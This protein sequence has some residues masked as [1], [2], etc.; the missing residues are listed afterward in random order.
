MPDT[1][2]PPGW[3]MVVVHDPHQAARRSMDALLPGKDTNAAF[4]ATQE[5]ELT[6]F[7]DDAER[8][9]NSVRCTA[10]CVTMRAQA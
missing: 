4:R 8:R 3:M 5:R 6:Q 1:W 10:C 9:L 7:A 2:A